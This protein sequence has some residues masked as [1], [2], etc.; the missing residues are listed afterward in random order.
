MN[1]LF[2]THNFYPRIGGIEVNSE[3]LAKAFS[4]AGHDVRLVTWTK[5]PK[6]TCFPFQI[7]RDPDLLV[8]LR[9]HKWAN[10]IFENNPSLRLSWPALFFRKPHVVAIRTWIT[11]SDGST[12]LK[13][14]LKTLWLK[15]ASRNIAVS[16]A[17]KNEC[18]KDAVVIGNPYR[19]DLF[20]IIP[21]IHRS[22]HFVFLG[23]LVSDKG[24]DH[25]IMA[26]HQISKKLSQEFSLTI[27]GNGPERTSLEKLVRKYRMEKSVRFTGSLRGEQLI[28][29]L[30][31]HKY[32]LIPSL[33]KEPFGNVA[34]EGLACGCIPIVSD[35][36]GLPE[37]IGEAG[38][39]FKRGDLKSLV[40]ILKRLDRFPEEETRLREKAHNHLKNYRSE[41][42]TKRYLE[43][44]DLTY[45]R[46]HSENNRITSHQ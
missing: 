26:V 24:A 27:I 7:F 29:Q 37:A 43:E 44:I 3:I 8:L 22:R 2:I 4:E 20:R 19:D 30:N 39:T 45:R 13:D 17:I 36:G 42:V 18:C 34:L 21:E 12:G 15:K 23:R 10:V 14:I 31:E 6:A 32:I 33:W 41:Y 25:A 9:L 46:Y 5:D 40:D 38:Y 1:I 11:R 35:G 28:S 16:S